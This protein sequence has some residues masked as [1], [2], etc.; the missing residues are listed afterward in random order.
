TQM[1]CIYEGS[2]KRVWQPAAKP[3]TLWFEFTDDYSVF[4]WGKMPDTIDCKGKALTAFGAYFFET[5]NEPTFWQQL[6][7][8]LAEKYSGKALWHKPDPT[9]LSGGARTPGDVPPAKVGAADALSHPGRRERKKAPYKKSARLPARLPGSD[10]GTR[11]ASESRHSQW[12][13]YLLLS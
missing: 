5:L 8:C 7:D 12:T 3:D 2:V 11:S 10:Q 9:G 6:P 4:D 1:N 13:D